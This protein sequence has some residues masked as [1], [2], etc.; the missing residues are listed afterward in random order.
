M[1]C[2]S[3]V[4]HTRRIDHRPSHLTLSRTHTSHCD[5]CHRVHGVDR[6]LLAR[7]GLAVY[8]VLELRLAQDSEGVPFVL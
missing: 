7:K 2:C 8:I 1:Y 4:H 5:N 6:R 3:A